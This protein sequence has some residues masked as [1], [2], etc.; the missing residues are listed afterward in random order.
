LLPSRP[1]GQVSARR[2]VWSPGLRASR[3]YASFLVVVVAIAVA[4]AWF[5]RHHRAEQTDALSAVPRDAWLVLSVDVA[6]LRGSPLGQTLLGPGG[7]PLPGVGSLQDACGFDPMSRI[8]AFVLCSPEGGERGDFGVA[9]GGTF[10]KAELSACADKVI[11]ARG[12]APST[13]ARGSF[14]V[15]DAGDAH[16]TR[17]AYRDGGPFLVGRGAWLDAMIDAAEGKAER[18]R[19][20]HRSLRSALLATVP[21]PVIVASALLPTSMRQRLRAELAVEV[22]AGD[23][24]AYA[25]VLAVQAAGLGVQTGGP[26]STTVLS[27]ALQCENAD[28]CAGVRDLALH[29]RQKLSGDFSVRALGLGPLLD[30][31]AIEVKDDAASASARIPTDDLAAGL[32]RLLAYRERHPGAP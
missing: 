7:L 3:Q 19:A 27:A 25:S 30:S 8:D 14:A 21:P 23:E 18:M 32:K 2:V 28:A 17:F 13:M 11:R 9:M 31:L 4:G 12:G 24:H 20:E 1:P 29:E 16:H 26:G 10:T 22:G 15:V 5:A 6:M